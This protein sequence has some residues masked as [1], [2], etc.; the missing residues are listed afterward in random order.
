MLVGENLWERKPIRWKKL[1]FPSCDSM[2][3]HVKSKAFI[4]KTKGF[5]GSTWIKIGA[6]CKKTLKNGKAFF[7]SIP[8][9]KGRIFQI[10][11]IRGST[12]VE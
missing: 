12:I 2:T 11:R 1:S 5:E 9:E 6:I 10:K 7:T 4:F 8:R 3:F